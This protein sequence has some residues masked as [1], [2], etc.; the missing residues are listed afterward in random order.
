MKLTKVITYS[1]SVVGCSPLEETLYHSEVLESEKS[2]LYKDT[3][4]NAVIGLDNS[5]P[6]EWDAFHDYH[7]KDTMWRA[8]FAQTF[9]DGTYLSYQL[10]EEVME[11]EIVKKW[12]EERSC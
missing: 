3:D 9:D 2:W 7:L 1:D 10:I 11:S 8:Y 4:W 12:K 6:E 5:D